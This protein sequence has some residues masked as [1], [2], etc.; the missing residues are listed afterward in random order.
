[1]KTRD[2]SEFCVSQEGI[3]APPHISYRKK[4][5]A[6][7]AMQRPSKLDPIFLHLQGVSLDEFAFGPQNTMW[8]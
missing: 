1:M 7:N 3:H 5:R 8:G 6:Q 2:Y 4:E